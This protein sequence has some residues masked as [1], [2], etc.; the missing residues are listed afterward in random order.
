MA[1]KCDK[2]LRE[3]GSVRLSDDR[4]M[5]QCD[6]CYF[7]KPKKSVKIKTNDS[8]NKAKVSFSRGSKG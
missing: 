2:C 5:W 6:D 7:D 4:T 3:F 8:N 1:Y